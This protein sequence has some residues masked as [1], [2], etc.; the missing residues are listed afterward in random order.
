MIYTTD[1]IAAIATPAAAG[2]IGIVRISGEQALAVAERIFDPVRKT[3][4]TAS[5]GYRAY[6]G[7][8]VDGEQTLD[9]AVCLVFRAPHSYTG[10]DVA[11]ISCHGGL[12]ITQRVLE[13]ALHAGARPAQAGEFTKRAFLHG[14]MDLSAAEAVMSMVSAQGEQAAKAALTALD[15]ALHRRIRAVA[16]KVIGAAAGMAAWVDYPDEDIEAVHND[17]LRETFEN[18]RAEL[19]ALLSRFDAGV[20]VTQGVDTVIVGRPNVGKSTLM[21][22]LAGTEKS[23]VTQI[24]GTTRDIVEQTVRLGNLVLHLSDT[25]G[26]RET[27]NPVE[28]IGVARARERME[29]AVLVLAVFD[30]ASPL[31][32]ED[33][34]LLEN[35]RGKLAV[36]VLNKED[37]GA[38]VDERTIADYV[39]AVV[40]IS[41]KDGSGYD[42]LC[43]TVTKLLGTDAFDPSAAMLANTR[44]KD[45]C[46]RAVRWL[47]E[48]IDA[49]DGG[50]TLDA[51]NVCADSCIE[52]LLELTGEKAG[53]AV[54]QEVFSRFCVGK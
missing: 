6:F 34:E 10:E 19:Q 20:A 30:G 7:H 17:K 28:Q 5:K 47:T 32:R 18:C 43:E 46:V 33:R 24:P 9:E 25:A 52:A 8:A 11:E 26:I 38:V 39:P 15:G 31:T 1:T 12:Y 54:V 50:Q 4:L 48:A 51:V 40:R 13:A 44:Q 27:E 16:D 23:I 45:C 29:R 14:K 42:A 3:A 36:A 49:L 22:L 35:C 2:G 53:E 41:A 37:Q 21:N